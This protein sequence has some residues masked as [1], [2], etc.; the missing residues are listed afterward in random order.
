MN[1]LPQGLVCG[2]HPG[3][4]LP[5]NMFRKHHHV[6]LVQ[7]IRSQHLSVANFYVYKNFDKVSDQ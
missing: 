6:L 2:N 7:S 4:L 3:V 1:F 5:V